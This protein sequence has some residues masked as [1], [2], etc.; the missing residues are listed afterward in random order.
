LARRT[1]RLSTENAFAAA[2]E[3]AAFAARGHR[4]YP[5]HLGDLDLPTPENISAATERAMRAGKTTY[6]PNAGIPELR[7]ALAETIGRA[8]SVGYAAGDL[9][10]K[11]TTSRYDNA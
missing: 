11:A 9:T 3:A 8:R 1:A 7:E 4:V 5:F 10:C 2:A 6:C